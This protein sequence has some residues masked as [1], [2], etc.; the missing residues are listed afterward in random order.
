MA[1]LRKRRNRWVIDFYDQYG[2]RRWKTLKEGTTKKKAKEAMRDIEDQVDRGFYIP[3]REVPLFSKVAKDWLKQKKPNLRETTWEVC[4]GHVN[5]HFKDLNNMKVNRITTATV[6]KYI[7]DRQTQGM[8]ISTLRKVLVTL[9]QILKYAAR[10]RYV[11]HNPLNDAE[12]PRSP[13]NESEE[14]GEVMVLEEAQVKA[15]LEKTEDPKYR[16]LFMLAIFTG[17]RQGEFLGL[18]WE[19][20]DLK[21]GEVHFKRTFNNGRFF[22]PKTRKSNRTLT[23]GP[24]TLT[25]LKK[26]RLACPKNELNL[27]FPNEAGEPLDHH[28]MVR[29]YFKPALDKAE[30][31]AI[32]FHDLRHTYASIRLDQGDSIGEVSEDL[33]HSTPTVTLNV[34]THKFRRNNKE[35]AKRLEKSILGGTGSKTVANKKKR[36]Q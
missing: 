15:L 6:E 24:V 21:S 4:E 34:Y 7:T 23:L 14:Q 18:K 32:R 35:A 20:I 3:A 33:G 28:N 29:R 31:P 36:S 9:N 26:W 8:N 22:A 12:R 25:E 30:L 13:G 11:D 17:A 2:K 1:C 27:L 10:H 19:D 16:M 5:N